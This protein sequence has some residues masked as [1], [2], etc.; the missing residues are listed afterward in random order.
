MF[1]NWSTLA[2][3]D[4]EEIVDYILVDNPSSA[5]TLYETIKQAVE[6]LQNY[7]NMGRIG[8]ISGTRE[9]VITNTPFIVAYRLQNNTVEILRILHS[10]RKWPDSF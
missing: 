4:L 5:F 7:P 1:I 8:R 3:N 10:S 6:K 9:L 2:S